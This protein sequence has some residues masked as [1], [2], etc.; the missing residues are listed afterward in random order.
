MHKCCFESAAFKI[1]LLSFV[2]PAQ[3]RQNEFFD[4]EKHPGS[5]CSTKITNGIQGSATGE[6]MDVSHVCISHVY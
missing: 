6:F 5:V 3:P 1:T 2:V 4:T